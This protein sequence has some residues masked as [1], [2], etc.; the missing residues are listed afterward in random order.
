MKEYQGVFR[1]AAMCRVLQVSTSGYYAW[2]RR[3]ESQRSRENRT[4]LAQIKAIHKES[5]RSY[6]PLRVYEALKDR[7]AVCGRHRVARL[8]REHDIRVTQKRRY[9]VTTDSRHAFPVA[10][11]LLDRKF[12]VKTPNQVWSADVTFIST[13]Q[14]WLYLAVVLD[15]FSR[16]VIGWSMSGRDQRQLKIRNYLGPQSCRI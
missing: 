12:D 11:N 9:K 4:L 6:G 3:G 2:N 5:R 10:E 7:G 16:R 15:L 14:G 8:M 1:I 13:R